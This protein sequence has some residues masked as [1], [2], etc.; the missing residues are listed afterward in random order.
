MLQPFLVTF[1]FGH[2]IKGFAIRVVSHQISLSKIQLNATALLEYVVARQQLILASL[3]SLDLLR[4]IVSATSLDF[5]R[6]HRFHSSTLLSFPNAGYPIAPD[7]LHSFAATL[8]KYF[9]IC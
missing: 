9:A 1:P 5:S 7:H 3:Q 6:T 8:L 2:L 4:Q